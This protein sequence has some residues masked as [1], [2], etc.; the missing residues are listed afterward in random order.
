MP[1]QQT[2]FLID[3]IKSMTKAEKRSFRLFSNMQNSKEDKLFVQLFDYIDGCKSYDENELLKKSPY[4][5]KQQ[6]PN[7]KSNLYQHLLN[8]LRHLNRNQAEVLLREMLDHAK[9]LLD[10][11]LY[12]AALETLDKVK[13]NAEEINDITLVYAAIEA[14]RKIES[15]YVTGSTAVKA[16]TIK[17][18]SNDI[19]DKIKVNNQLANLSLMLYG[20]YLKYGYV[21]DKKEYEFVKDFFD[22]HIPNVKVEELDFTGKIN[23]YQSSVWYYHMIQDF[24]SYFKFSQKWVDLFEEYPEMIVNNQILY[25]KGLHNSLN[26]LYMA[27]KPQKFFDS[28][29]KYLIINDSIQSSG[30]KNELSN[31]ELFKNIHLL[32]KIIL[33]ADYDNGIKSLK[34]L[35]TILKTNSYSWDANRVMVFYYKIAC[36]Y[37]GADDFKNSLEYLNKIINY[38]VVNFRLDIQAFARILSL[39]AHFELGNETLVKYQIMSVYRFLSKQEDLQMVQKEIFNFLRKTPKISRKNIKKEFTKLREALIK[40]TKDPYERR[41]FLYLDIVAWLDSKIE[42][43]RIQDVIRQRK[44]RVL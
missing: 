28:F 33:S 23:Y 1:K 20:L 32:N 21:K 41:P 31:Y 22:T 44:E 2:E 4:I 34:E 16:I 35:T 26:A 30:N 7:I 42:G 43:R 9:I 24:V 19:T 3:L 38:P 40:H 10:K 37:F 18:K 29:E 17:D 5:K 11:G 14:E 15:Q 39:I 13:R 6:L 36:V 8:N 27:H 12:K 25:F